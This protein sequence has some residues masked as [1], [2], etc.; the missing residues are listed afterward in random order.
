MRLDVHDDDRAA[1]L[2]HR[3]RSRSRQRSISSSKRASPGRHDLAASMQAQ[4]PRRPLEGAQHHARCGRS[5]AGGRS[6]PR[7]CR[8]RRDRRPCGRR[9]PAASRSAPLAT[10][11]R[12]RRRPAARCRR[13]TAAAERSRRDGARRCVRRSCRWAKFATGPAVAAQARLYGCSS[14]SSSAAP[15][16]PPRSPSAATQRSAGRSTNRCGFIA[17][18][19]RSR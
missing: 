6:S 12:D 10:R 18:A 5:R 8:R 13:R 9:A 15:I 19:I 16:A 11:S 1:R 7:R 17:F 4:D 2:G 3:R 14:R